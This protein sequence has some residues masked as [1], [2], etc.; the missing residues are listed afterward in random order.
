M[1]RTFYTK[2]S[3]TI[4]LSYYFPAEMPE[5]SSMMEWKRYYGQLVRIELEDKD[6]KR[7][8]KIASL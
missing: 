4:S 3:K 2:K 1:T 6:I 5:V 8:Y 7:N